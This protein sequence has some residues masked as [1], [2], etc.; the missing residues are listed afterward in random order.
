MSRIFPTPAAL[1]KM[2]LFGVAL[3][4]TLA[5]GVVGC[6]VAAYIHAAS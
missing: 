2:D 3:G 1:S 6:I 5:A 4:A